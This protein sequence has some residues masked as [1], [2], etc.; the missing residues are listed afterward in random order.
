[1]FGKH[2]ACVTVF[3]VMLVLTAL[4]PILIAV[5][6]TLEIAPVLAGYLGIFLLGMTFISVGVLM[7]ALTKNQLVAF[8]LAFGVL[9]LFWVLGFASA[10]LDPKLGA[11]LSHAS[12]IEHVNNFSRGLITTRDVVYYVN[13]SVFCLFLTV[14]ALASHRWKG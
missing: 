3:L 13:F 6:G 7:S 8:I 5:I 9:L 14:Q 12:L 2:L 1:M 4:Y 10:I 11:A